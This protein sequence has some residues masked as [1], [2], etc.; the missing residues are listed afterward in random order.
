MGIGGQAGS[1]TQERWGKERGRGST[2][3]GFTILPF[4]VLQSLPFFWDF[5]KVAEVGM[6][7]GGNSGGSS[8]TS[9]HCP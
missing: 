9:T 8:C 6:V 2:F 5:F 7:E 1:V 4:W 3:R